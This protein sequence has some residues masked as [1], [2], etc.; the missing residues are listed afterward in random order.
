[1]RPDDEDRFPAPVAANS[2][3]SFGTAYLMAVQLAE[4]GAVP[5]GPA[6]GATP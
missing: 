6:L 1:M 3:T 2:P 4:P 5:A